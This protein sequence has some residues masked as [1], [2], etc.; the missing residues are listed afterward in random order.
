M[1]YV[2]A[3]G[4]ARRPAGEDALGSSNVAK[5]AKSYVVSLEN[6]KARGSGHERRDEILAAARELFLEKGVENVST[7]QLATRVGIS[8]TAFYHYF[9]TK[10]QL[11]DQ[12]MTSAFAKLG[13]VLD[14]VTDEDPV[15]AVAEGGR[16][17]V[18]F[19]LEHPDE[20]RL[21]FMLRD[22]RRMDVA[23]GLPL[24]SALGEACFARLEGKIA[25]GMA[26]GVFSAGDA[27]TIARSVQA[28]WHGVVAM[29]LAFPEFGHEPAD[30]LIETHVAMV[31]KSIGARGGLG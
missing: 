15:H 7:R 12:L 21:A 2:G 19:G 11:L 29:L 28:S 26:S 17:Y 9:E 27:N 31:V 24:R 14:G 5:A 30:V 8:Q 20:Y 1:I 10:E 3:K 25:K 22:G 16:L 13:H 18:R 6:R 4:A 23:G